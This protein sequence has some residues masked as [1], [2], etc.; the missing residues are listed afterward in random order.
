MEH[1]SD[2][3]ARYNHKR[4]DKGTGGITIPGQN[5]PGSDGNEE[6]LRIP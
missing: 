1:E 4:M 5:G 2:R 6:V 3:G